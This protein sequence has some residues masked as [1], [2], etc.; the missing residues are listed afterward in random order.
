MDNIMNFIKNIKFPKLQR[1]AAAVMIFWGVLILASIGFFIFMRGFTSCWQLTSLPGIPPASCNNSNVN[2]LGTPVLN[3]EGTPMAVPPTPQSLPAAEAPQWDGGSRI[4]ILF[5]GLRAGGGAISGSDCP[6]CTDTIILAT[7]DPV[8][9]TAGML[10]IP[11]DLYVNIPGF[12][13]SRINTAYTN[14]QGAQLPGGGPGLAMK[15][16]SQIT[17]VPI[18]YYITV[19]FSTFISAINDIGGIDLYVSHKLTLDPL[20][21]G[22]DHVV[23]TCCGMRHLTGQAALA[24]ARTRDT[25][26]GAVNGDIGRSQ[27]QQ[28]VIYAIRDKIFNPSTFPQFI[29]QAPNLYKK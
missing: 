12:G 9:K 24:Y 27:R 3:P 29:T 28:Q 10:S 16:V 8:S 18:Q 22:L 11:R 23:V 14:G 4:N 6:L 5:F 13:Y 20:G 15:T 26:Q 17:G 1:P 7:I 21:T 25:S 19:D 2:V